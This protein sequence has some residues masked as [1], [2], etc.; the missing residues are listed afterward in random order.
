MR[1]PCVD[2]AWHFDS[3]FE[4]LNN[5][6]LQQQQQEEQEQDPQQPDQP[7]AAQGEEVVIQDEPLNGF[8]VNASRRLCPWASVLSPLLHAKGSSAMLPVVELQD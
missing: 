5:P 3:Q 2:P 7:A 4:L 6:D 1:D 8:E